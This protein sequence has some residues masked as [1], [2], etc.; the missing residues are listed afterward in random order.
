MAQPLL[1]HRQHLLVAAAFRVEHPLRPE[2]GAGE[3][4][5]EQVAPAERPQHGARQAGGDGGDE[6]GRRRLVGQRGPRPR[7]L[8]QS[9]ER[10]PA[11]GEPAVDL[12]D[13]ERKHPRAAPC[14]AGTFDRPHLGA[15]GGQTIGTGGNVGH[16]ESGLLCS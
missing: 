9:P 10:Q 7:R 4:G 6:Q 13:P 16:R 5:R 2:P 3:A 1:H 12:P 11:T 14:G 8:V 15:Q